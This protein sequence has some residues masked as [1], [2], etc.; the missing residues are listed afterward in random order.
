MTRVGL[1]SFGKMAAIKKGMLLDSPEMR[2][3]ALHLLSQHPSH[4]YEIIKSVGKLTSGVYAPSPGMVYPTLT[5][6]EK[7]SYATSDM[8]GGKKLFRI[9]KEGTAFL[10]EHQ[11]QLTEVLSRIDFLG[12]KMASMQQHMAQE[13]MTD[14]RWG[15]TGTEN[16]AFRDLRHELKTVLFEKLNA[17]E[18]EKGRIM[19]I[20]R[21]AI[22]T[23]R[24]K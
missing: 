24:L 3:I 5:Y 20:M 19:K 18:Q 12:R 7:L 13:Q 9:T 16:A 14:E 2:L 22:D 1:E 4:G 23:I 10:T 6:I 21:N 8:Q 15:A 11:G 17:S